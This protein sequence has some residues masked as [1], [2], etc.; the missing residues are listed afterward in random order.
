VQ[1][2]WIFELALIEKEDV[3][4]GRL[5]ASENPNKRIDSSLVL[6]IIGSNVLH[7]RFGSSHSE[8]LDKGRAHVSH[9]R[10]ALSWTVVTPIPGSYFRDQVIL[11]R[12]DWQKNDRDLLEES[13]RPLWDQASKDEPIDLGRRE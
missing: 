7:L 1:F 9:K 13:R 3:V 6:G 11:K 4:C 8:P 2:S 10:T 12:A 5:M